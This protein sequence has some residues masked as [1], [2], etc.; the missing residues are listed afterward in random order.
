MENET[1]TVPQEIRPISTGTYVGLRILFLIPVVGVVLALIMSFA[2]KN[3]NMKYFCRAQLILILI[4][5]AITV[6]GR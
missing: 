4:V 3:I 5:V 2:P 6:T 1:I